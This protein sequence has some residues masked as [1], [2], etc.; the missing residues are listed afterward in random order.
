MRRNENA[1][2]G[3]A[4]STAEEWDPPPGESTAA[5]DQLSTS[6]VWKAWNRNRVRGCT[7]AR[8]LRTRGLPC[9]CQMVVPRHGMGRQAKHG[10]KRPG[11]WV[12]KGCVR[13]P[14]EA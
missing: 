7:R 1:R 13:R 6:R 12:G 3:I 10:K 4:N 14:I 2:L 9:Q 5:V 8:Q 11:V